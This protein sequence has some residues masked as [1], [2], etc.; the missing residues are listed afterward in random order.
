MF[1]VERQETARVSGKTLVLSLVLQREGGGLGKG[2][3]MGNGWEENGY[4]ARK[5]RGE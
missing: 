3:Q 2:Q 5:G 4:G 1:P